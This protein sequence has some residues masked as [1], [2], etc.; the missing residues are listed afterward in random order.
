MVIDSTATIGVI[1]GTG[2]LGAALAR[3][4]AKAGLRV[5]IGSRDAD[6][7]REAAS[8]LSAE[9]G[10]TV[11]SG[12]NAEVAA[13]ADLIVVSVPF[14]SQ[15]ATLEEIRDAVAGKIVIDTTVPLMPPK[16]MRV[17]MP[18]EGCAALR[19]QQ[20]LGDTARVVSAFHNVAAHKLAT[21]ETVA[22]DVLVFGD[23]KD[24]RAQA[25]ALAE[26]AGLR[27]LH[28]GAL[29]NSAAAEAMT[30]VL[31]FLNRSYSVD[32]AGIRITGNLDM[33]ALP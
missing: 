3:R 27:G 16:V 28:A 22:C 12:R 19:A 23:D 26:A 6:K 1:G 11:E 7:A 25:V 9:S 29:A 4:W 20:V 24:A 33:T 17:Q 13:R 10:A 5:A 32:G 15:V 30:S 18:P 2:K 31:I 14:A 8:A 21:D